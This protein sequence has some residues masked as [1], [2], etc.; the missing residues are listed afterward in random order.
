MMRLIALA[1]ILSISA[2]V[3]AMPVVSIQQSD[4]MVVTVRQGCGA[5]FQR[6]GNRCVRNTAVRTFR[7]CAAGLRLVN[8]RCIR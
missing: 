5:G 7:R 1:F 8:G 4:D 2:S 6:V 3:H